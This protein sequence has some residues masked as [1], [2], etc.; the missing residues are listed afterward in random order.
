MSRL[1]EEGETWEDVLK[2]IISSILS[3]PELIFSV[4][5]FFLS[6]Y[7]INF[8]LLQTHTRFSRD[9]ESIPRSRWF[10]LAM[11]VIP[12]SL[13]LLIYHGVVYSSI[14]STP[15]QLSLSAMPSS[16]ILASVTFVLLIWRVF[17]DDR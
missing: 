15:E 8:L 5:F 2:R 13:V 10:N 16:L 14:P 17:S 9:N 1:S 3:V 11:G 4:P 6:G 7:L 12:G